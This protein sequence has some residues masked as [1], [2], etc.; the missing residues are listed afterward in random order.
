MKIDDLDKQILWLLSKNGRI[1]SAEIA[2]IVNDNDRK[3]VY[4]VNRLIEKGAIY[5]RGV[6]NHEVFDYRIRADVHIQVESR[7]VDEAAEK[8]AEFEEVMYVGKILGGHEISIQVLLKTP[9]D[10]YKFVSEKIASISGVTRTT[11][12]LVPI[13]IKNIDQWAPPEVAEF[14]N[15]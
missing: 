9:A 5:I 14:S 1:S 15:E 4:R 7:S 2:G 11:T 12:H 6:I 8:M 10:L 13:I 3:I